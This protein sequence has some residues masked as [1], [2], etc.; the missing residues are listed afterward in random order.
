MAEHLDV[1]AGVPSVRYVSHRP[2][3]P[4]LLRKAAGIIKSDTLITI[5]RL[6]LCPL[7]VTWFAVIVA[8]EPCHGGGVTVTARTAAQAGASCWS[9]GTRRRRSPARKLLTTFRSALLYGADQDT[10]GVTLFQRHQRLVGLE[11]DALPPEVL[12]D[13]FIA[14][15]AEFRNRSARRALLYRDVR[16]RLVRRRR[17]GDQD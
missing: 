11:G 5:L 15:T 13:A 14:A 1:L 16:D 3:W 6:V 8:L 12:W 7:L 10:C 9:R 2:D 17:W 4:A